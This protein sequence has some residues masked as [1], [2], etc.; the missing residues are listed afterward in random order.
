MAAVTGR[1]SGL[2]WPIRGL[3]FAPAGRIGTSNRATGPV[4]LDFDG[5]GMLAILPKTRLDR[6]LAAWRPG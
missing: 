6:L 1:S 4:S 2:E 3:N 5:D